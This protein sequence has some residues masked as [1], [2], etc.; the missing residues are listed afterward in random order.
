[1]AEPLP[2][3]KPFFICYSHRD[4]ADIALKLNDQL[5][6]GVPSIAVWLDQRKLQ[7]GIDRYQQ[8]LQALKDCQGVLYLVTNDSVDPSCPCTQEWIRALK[9]KKPIIPLIVHSD[10]ELPFQLE[11]RVP[12]V[13]GE[14]EVGL[15]RL[16]EHVRWRAT[17]A[18]LLHTMNEQLKD[19]L[20]DL[21]GALQADKVRIEEEIAQLQQQIKA[22]QAAIEN[23]QAA[24]D[25]TQKNIERGL[26]RERQPEVPIASKMQTRFINRPPL[27]PPIYFQDRHVE[28]G[29]IGAFLR[30]DNMRLMTVVGRGGV[31]KTA[32]VCRLLRS[33][34]GGKLPDNGG[35]LTVDGIVYL[36]TRSGHPVN[37][38]NLFYDLCKL[39]PEE[40]AKYL[41][42]LYKDPTQS[43]KAQMEALLAE[44]PRGRTVVL[45]DNFEDVV[46]GETQTIKEAELD[47]ALRAMLESPPHGLKFII[48][49]RVAP[50]A[51]LRVQPGLQAS[52]ELDQGL[53]SPYAENVLKAMDSSGTLGLNDPDAPLTEAREATRGFPRALEAIV[54]ILRTDR[55]TDLRG[56]LKEMQRLGSKADDVVRDLVGEAFNRLDPL[57]QEVMQALAVYGAPV[58]AVAVDYL[59]QAYRVGIDSSKTLGRLVNMQ[60][61]RGEASRFY[62][63]QVDRDYA[64]SRL[65]EGEPN[66]RE[67]EPPPLTRYALRHRAAEYFKETRKPRESWKMLEDLAPQLAEYELRLA[68]EDYNAAASVLIEIDDSYLSLWGHYH[69]LADRYERLQ[70]KLTDVILEWSSMSGLGSA[71]NRTGQFEKGLRCFEHT[72][73]LA[74]TQEDKWRE[75]SSLIALSWVYGDLGDQ[76]KAIEF[77]QQGIRL[78]EEVGDKSGEATARGNL[79]N[80]FADVGRSAEAIE[81]YARAITLHKESRSREGECRDTYN[82]ADAYAELG[83]T[84]EASKLARDARQMAHTIGYK[85]IESAAT[86]LLGHLLGREGRVQDSIRA[87]EEACAIADNSNAVQMQMV[88]RRNLAWA[89]LLA[90]DLARA[91]TV[92]EEAAKYRYPKEYASTLVL[93]GAVALRQGD[94]AAASNAFD[95]ALS[96]AEAQLTGA[97][98]AYG[99]AYD[100]AL[101]LAGL[102]LCRDAALATAAVEAYRAARAISATP[103]IVIDELQALD[104]LAVADPGGTLKPVRAAAAGE[105]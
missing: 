8:V 66:D 80:R 10:A 52:L 7:P 26:E 100:K 62:L 33:L 65:V 23:P 73:T 34:E 94:I 78:C 30:N 50:L 77:A 39:V 93:A 27:I 91:R 60:F 32:M 1:M 45:L 14:T 69:M 25:E 56:L 47:E 37:F 19:A 98:R 29:L 92:G 67:E 3:A 70:G 105:V 17:P 83:K 89:C 31:G 55:S 82:L 101:A 9:Y 24:R 72:L 75:A 46:E 74:R 86:S 71:Y 88:A 38:P 68:G 81:Q 36:S 40:E 53:K 49:T 41:D 79:A 2:V 59:L 84:S 4:G 20:R 61:V 54:G 57:A 18:G 76:A 48:T 44:F 58:P 96:E 97:T 6:A 15:A 12:I 21:V 11:P 99:S 22:L 90:G 5:M 87:H 95:R 104:A 43:V 13:F 51:L 35:D 16:R 102:A 28:T 64:L 85:L 103:G 63:H 42:E